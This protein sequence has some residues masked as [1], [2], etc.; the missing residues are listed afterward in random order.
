MKYS[1]LIK[2]PLLFALRLS[3]RNNMPVTSYIQNVVIHLRLASS[4]CT[5]NRN[6]TVVRKKLSVETTSSS[7]LLSMSV[8]CTVLYVRN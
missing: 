6:K 1:E 4:V 8:A 3:F 5:E 7:N 2:S